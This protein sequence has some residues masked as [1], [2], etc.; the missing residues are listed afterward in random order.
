MQT[1]GR[2]WRIEAVRRGDNDFRLIHGDNVIDG[3]PIED[4]QEVLARAGVDM[5]SLVK[6]DASGA[7]AGAA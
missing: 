5:A 2:Q 4:L 1:P 7:A 3:L 6:A